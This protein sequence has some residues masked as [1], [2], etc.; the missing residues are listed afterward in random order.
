MQ[1]Q[2][3]NPLKTDDFGPAAT[4][5]KEAQAAAEK[6]KAALDAIPVDQDAL[7]LA[8]RNDVLDAAIARLGENG[9]FWISGALARGRNNEDVGDDGIFSVDYAEMLRER[10][11]KFC[12]VGAIGAEWGPHSFEAVDEAIDAVSRHFGGDDG[13]A[14]GFKSGGV[15]NHNDSQDEETGGAIIVNAFRAAKQQPLSK[16]A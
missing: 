1:K 16:N 5:N 9:E 12:L 6:V 8:E 13:D 14:Y 3:T 11:H 2:Q 7:L 4:G 10:G 15:F